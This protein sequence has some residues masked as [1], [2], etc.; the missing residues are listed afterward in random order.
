MPTNS[1][2]NIP[3]RN[4]TI[5]PVTGL[6]HAPPD[7]HFNPTSDNH[8]G[9]AFATVEEQFRNTES[10]KTGIFCAICHSFAATRDTPYHNYERGGTEYVPAVG[11]E[12]RSDLLP[13]SQQDLFK[14]AD[15]TKRNLGYS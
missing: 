11:A 8:T 15:P 3:L 7:T 9:I 14:V 4:V 13:V 10:G 6:E 2:D 1:L 5:N 12:S